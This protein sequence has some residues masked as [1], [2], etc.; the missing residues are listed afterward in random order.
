[1]AVL[2]RV[3]GMGKV[4]SKEKWESMGPDYYYKKRCNTLIHNKDVVKNR[5]TH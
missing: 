5:K 1:M 4:L 3:T 2:S